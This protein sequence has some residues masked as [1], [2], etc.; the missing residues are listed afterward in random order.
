MRLFPPA[1]IVG[2]TAM[3]DLE[4]CG[5]RIP[6]KSILLVSQ[7]LNHRAPEYFPEP[8]TFD[9]DRFLPEAVAARPKLSYFPFGAGPRQCAGEAFAWMEGVLVLA[10]LARSWRARLVPDQPL[11]LLPA[12]TLRPKN[13]LRMVLERRSARFNA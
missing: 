6:A 8:E 12:I 2:R 1:W 9:P 3:Q 10:T 13:G 7:Y 4:V 5:H 11:E